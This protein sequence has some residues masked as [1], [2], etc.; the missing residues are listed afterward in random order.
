MSD[1]R[2]RLKRLKAITALLAERA[3]APV[4]L[5]GAKV[6]ELENKA[7][8]LAEHRTQLMRST[9]DPAISATMQRQAERLRVQQAAQLRKLASARA[10]YQR[11]KS[12]AARAVGRDLVLEKLIE[13]EEAAAKAELDRRNRR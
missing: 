9:A 10:V 3:L 6:H 12:T 2:K 5:A 1:Q 4:K 13:N 8:S 7:A 11:E